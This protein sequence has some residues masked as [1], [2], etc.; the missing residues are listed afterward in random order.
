MRHI[1]L[2]ITSVVFII[3]SICSYAQ[4]LKTNLR[5]QPFDNNWKFFLADDAKAAT[6]NFTDSS[7]R[8][9]NLAYDWSI[10]GNFSPS[11]PTGND[12]GYLPAGIGWYRKTFV[13][14]ADWTNK[15]ISI[16]FGGVYMSSEVFING[17]SLGVYPYGC[18]SFSYELTPYLNYGKEN[19]IAVRVDNSQQKNCRWYSGSGI[20]R[21]VW[22][23]ATNN[24]H[25]ARWDT[26]ITAPKV[27]AKEATVEV[28]TILPLGMLA[29]YSYVLL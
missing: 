12:G 9:V 28:T 18:S 4:N 24:V 6:S 3:T 15:S 19:T 29:M 11:N 14:P 25:I 16:Y 7:W 26:A 21:H 8:D 5:D 20:Y 2:L 27:T 13:I 22:I 10:E 17:K 1:K 23:T